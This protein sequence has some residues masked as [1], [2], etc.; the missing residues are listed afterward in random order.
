[1]AND[2]TGYG[3]VVHINASKTF[4]IEGLTITQFADDADPLDFASIKIADIAMGVNGDLI[5]WSRAVPVPMVLNVIPGSDDD[6]NLQALANANTASQ[7]KSLAYDV[8]TATV[9]YPDGTSVVCRGGKMTDSS[10]AKSISSAG[11]L[12]T[13]SYAFAFQ[14]RA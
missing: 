2:I 12:K 9:V 4:P 10:T 3:A 5:G 11:R 1:M 8:I 13:K 7:G 14:S 6:V